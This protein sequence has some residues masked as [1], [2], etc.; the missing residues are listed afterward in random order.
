[1]SFILKNSL[2]K[3][4]KGY[5]KRQCNWESES[6]IPELKASVPFFF[7]YLYIKTFLSA[8]VH[9][10][11][12]WSIHLGSYC[13]NIDPNDICFTDGQ[14]HVGSSTLSSWCS[15]TVGRSKQCA[16]M[17]SSKQRKST[18]IVNLSPQNNNS[19]GRCPE[20]SFWLVLSC[21]SLEPHSRI[22]AQWL[23]LSIIWKLFK[24]R[25]AEALARLVNLESI[26]EWEEMDEGG[27]RWF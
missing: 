11:Q 16:S 25:G 6:T 23:H 19:S 14:R 22:H 15:N 27:P 2:Q 8:W 7:P 3:S 21:F 4:L 26:G 18:G 24:T 20:I 12:I 10:H 9:F 13:L 5:S 17:R 1:M